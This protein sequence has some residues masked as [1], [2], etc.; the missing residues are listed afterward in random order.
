[1]HRVARTSRGGP[2]VR[3]ACHKAFGLDD[4]GALLDGDELVAGY[5]CSAL[6]SAVRPTDF[7]VGGEIGP[8]AENQAEIIGAARV[9]KRLPRFPDTGIN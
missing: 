7:Q 2:A 4:A 1:M 3:P 8:E 6:D 9:S 5:D